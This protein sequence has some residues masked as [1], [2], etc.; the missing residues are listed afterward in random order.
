MVSMFLSFGYISTTGSN[1][2]VVLEENLLINKVTTVIGVV[3]MIVFRVMSD[4]EYKNW[5]RHGIMGLFRKPDG[6]TKGMVWFATDIRYIWTILVRKRYANRRVD[7]AYRKL[8]TFKLIMKSNA[9]LVTKKELGFINVAIPSKFAECVEIEELS[10]QDVDEIRHTVRVNPV[11]FYYNRRG[12][13]LR[14]IGRKELNNILRNGNLFERP[15]FV[16]ADFYT[17]V[18][19]NKAYVDEVKNVRR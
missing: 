6:K 12:E 7:E 15:L 13:L 16:R 19:R 9:K 11:L 2:V 1:N 5:K 10:C 8:V 18:W 3:S 17:K 4:E 14:V